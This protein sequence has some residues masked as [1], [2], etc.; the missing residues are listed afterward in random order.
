[1]QKFTPTKFGLQWIFGYCDA[2][3][4]KTTHLPHALEGLADREARSYSP[5]DMAGHQQGRNLK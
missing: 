4:Q 2:P 5:A 3:M 1:M